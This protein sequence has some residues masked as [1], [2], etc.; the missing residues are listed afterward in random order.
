M[1]N[2]QFNFSNPWLLFALIPLLVFAL[3]PYFRLA[4]KYRRTRNRVTSV[5]LHSIICVFAVFMLAGLTFNYEIP[6]EKNEVILLVDCSDSN[7]E[8]TE[9]KEN[10]VRS[11]VDV[12][13]DDYKIGIVKFGYDAKYVAPLSSDSEAVYRKYLASEDP[14]TTATD[15]ASAIQYASTLFNY[16]ETGKIV[17]IS[18]GIE[19]DGAVTSVIKSVSST[20]IKVDTAYFENKTYEG[21]QIVD[22]TTPDYAIK[23]DE[24]FKLGFT[25]KHNFSEEFKPFS[26]TVYDNGKASS[27]YALMLTDN[28]QYFEIDYSLKTVGMHELRLVINAADDHSLKNNS[29]TTY[30]NLQTFENV[31][32]VERQENESIELQGILSD[33]FNVTALSIEQDLQLIPRSVNEMCDY[34][35]I[36]LVN[37]AYSDMP[38]GFE[39]NLNEYVYKLGGGL[40]TVGGNNDTDGDG[41]IIPHAYNRADMEQ[42]TYYKQMLPVMTTDYT[43]P[44]AVMI[45]VDISGSMSM[46]KLDAAKLGAEACLDSLSDRDYCGITSF[47]SR[48]SEELSVV[49]VSQRQKIKDAIKAIGYENGEQGAGSGGTIFSDAIIRAGRALSVV[50][51]ERKHIIMVTDGNPS[52]N[53]EQYGPYIDQNV[54]DE[55]TMS[56]VTID[57]DT[58]YTSLMQETAERAG[59]EYYNVALSNINTLPSI[60]QQD[61]ALEAIGEIEYGEEFTPKIRDYNSVVA[62]IKQSDMPSLTGYYGTL[63]KENAI[64]PLYGPYVPIYAQWKYGEGNVGSFM[65]DLNGTWSKDFITDTVGKTIILN[66]VSS[67]FPMEDVVPVDLEIVLKE[68]NYSSQLNVYGAQTGEKV[69]VTVTQLAL[70][71]NDNSLSDVNVKAEESNRRFTFV[72]KTAGVYKIAVVK[73]DETGMPLSET[74]LYK[75][76]SYSEEYNE[77]PNKEP[78][79]KELLEKIALDGKGA[80]ITDPA[81]VFGDFVK[82]L[83]RTYDPRIIF[84]ILIIVLFLL[85]V[86]V[87]KFKFKW[88]HELIREYRER[89]ASNQDK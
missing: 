17:L 78:I 43:P 88:P 83:K 18:D 76:F 33:T 29:Y 36:I 52:D 87:R 3:I 42:S 72:I 81:T 56:I 26:L 5:V 4:K 28:E 8:K 89:K 25:V 61:L 11:V 51:V 54:E 10:F 20:G 63:L 70:E 62:G 24:N 2:F 40:F 19:T 16:P 13:G 84:L 38:A 31:L 77:F 46:G 55:I 60:M 79:G 80:L 85:D 49:P 7:E 22:A 14:D 34:E 50:D 57:A 86:A 58:D 65:S 41:D 6:N 21:I 30:I 37:I 15:V 59:G 53:M 64:A 74:V 12:C 27:P 73:T 48:S 32:I 69:E 75:T 1:T 45:V 23:V 71:E 39:E 9:S 35:Q 68:D 82:T 67:L 47:S 66:I 44:V